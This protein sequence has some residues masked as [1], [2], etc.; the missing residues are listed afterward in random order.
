V[1]A[2]SDKERLVDG[3]LALADKLFRELL[4]TVPRDLLSLDITMPQMKILV[5]LY[6]TGPRRM[7]DV[8]SELD[9]TLPTATSLVERLVE[10]RYVE[11]ETNPDDRRVVLCHLSE[12]GEQVI[13]HIWQSAGKR[14]RE[15]LQAMDVSKLELFAEAL[16]AMHETALV[17]RPMAARS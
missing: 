9:V 5:I 3:I 12:A 2:E 4:P 10:K 15:L 13:K 7:S 1:T 14:S 16:Q 6:V 17:E 11:R 8:A